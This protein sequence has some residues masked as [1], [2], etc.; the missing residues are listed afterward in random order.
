MYIYIYMPLIIK[1]KLGHY[2]QMQLHRVEYLNDMADAFQ[3]RSKNNQLRKHFVDVQRINKYSPEY[4]RI[5]NHVHNS[6][7]QAMNRDS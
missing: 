7:T 4:E 5:R 1:S 3:N 2:Q 6:A